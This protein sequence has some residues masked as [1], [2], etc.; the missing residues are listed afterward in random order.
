MYTHPKL[1]AFT[2]TLESLFHQVDEILEVKWEGLYPLHPNRPQKGATVNPEMDGLF[3]IAPDFTLGLGSA[4]GRGYRIS[5]RIATL[6]PVS[7][8]N[9]ELLLGETAALVA[10]RLPV[11]FPNRD[12]RVVKDPGGYKIIGD[13]SLGDV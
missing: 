11:F 1:E 4:H 12:L 5:M 3:E 2:K 8:E 7:A 9:R 6:D 13:F 10:E